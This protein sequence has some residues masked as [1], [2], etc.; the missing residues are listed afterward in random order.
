MAQLLLIKD[1][2]DVIGVFNDS[3]KFSEHE[4]DIFDIVEVKGTREKIE[5]ER[6]DMLKI[7]VVKEKL[8]YADGSDLKKISVMPTYENAYVDNKFTNNI[9]KDIRNHV[10]LTAEERIG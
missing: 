10:M 1:T 2:K 7:S 9:S 8:V 4:I 6:R 5:K 3:H